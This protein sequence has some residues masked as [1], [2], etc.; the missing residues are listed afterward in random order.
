MLWPPHLFRLHA[1]ASGASQDVTEATLAQAHAV[2]AKGLP[3]II[4]LRHLAA[5]AAVPY[6]TLRAFVDRR[7]E[8][9]R[10]FRIRKRKGGYRNIAVP[11]P[12]LLRCQQ[13][14]NGAVLQR[15]PSSRHSYAYDGRS[16]QHCAEQHLGCTW[17]LRMDVRRFFESISERQVYHVFFGLGYE[18]LVAHELARLTTRV[19]AEDAV[20]YRCRR[21]R[22]RAGYKIHVHPAM[23]HLP[24][25]AATSPRLSNLVC[26]EMD[27]EVAK[28]AGDYGAVYTRYADDMHFSALEGGSRARLLA[29]SCEV[30]KVMGAFGMRSNASK[31]YIAGPGARRLVLGFLVDGVRV[32][33]PLEV[34]RRLFLELYHL[35]KRGPVEHVRRLGF[36]SPLGYR[37]HLQGRIWYYG[38]VEDSIRVGAQA[39]FD[40]VIWPLASQ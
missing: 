29:L 24:Q 36:E 25:G 34:R 4:S 40:S 27:V 39:E 3:A 38:R 2:Q 9:Y 31:L 6:K 23:G 35:R 14:I 37:A 5:L 10:A 28:R 1:Q 11:C 7:G 16:P 22:S 26:R 12:A 20:R 18:P 33:V 8:P 30:S 21:W 19:Y 17:L 13:W 15:V 32:R